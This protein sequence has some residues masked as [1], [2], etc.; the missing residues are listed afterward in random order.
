M[1]HGVTDEVVQR[2][3]K[4]PQAAAAE[5]FLG[6]PSLRIDGVDVERGAEGRVDFGLKCRLYR[7]ADGLGGVPADE[8]IQSALA[9]HGRP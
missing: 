8:L 5:R 7:R 9:A 6:S 2:R 1:Q 4:S 3:V